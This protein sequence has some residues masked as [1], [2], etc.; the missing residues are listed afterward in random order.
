MDI[1]FRSFGGDET[2]VDAVGE[3]VFGEVGGEVARVKHL[4]EF[5][6]A[7]LAV[8]AEVGVEFVQGEELCI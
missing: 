3:D 8:G 2:G 5:G 4:G 6:A 7:V 1:L